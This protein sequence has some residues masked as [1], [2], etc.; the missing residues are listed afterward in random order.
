[1]IRKVPAMT[2]RQ[3]L[4]EILNE[5]QYRKASVL[6]I[7]GKKAVAAIVDVNL[8]EKIRLLD[9]EFQQLTKQL[10]KAYAGVA[11]EKAEAEISEAL[12]AARKK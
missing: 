4:G 1:M 2:V 7:K 5:V 12:R 3:N 10:G 8:F 6:I 11:P 9:S